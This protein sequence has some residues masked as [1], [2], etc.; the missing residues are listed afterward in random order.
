[1]K[2]I[3]LVVL[4]VAA[5]CSKKAGSDC[6]AAIGKGMDSFTAN[7][8]EHAPNPQVLEKMM[9]MVDKL[10]STLTERC[11]A[12]GWTPEATACF[13]AVANRKD[14]QGCQSKLTP[15]QREQADLRAHAGDDERTGGLRPGSM[16]GMPPGM[17]G[18]PGA[19]APGGGSDSA[20]APGA[21]PR[22]GSGARGGSGGGRSGGGC[23]GWRLRLCCRRLGRLVIDRS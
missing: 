15:E 1:M 20:A 16:G 7:M 6:D 10:K 14:M 11:K 18:H 21:A 13:A 23:G 22:C 19:L 12:D 8:K 17:A 2:K 5:G 9:G 3:L 4:L